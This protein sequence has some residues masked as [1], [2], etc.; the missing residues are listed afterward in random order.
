M[1]TRNLLPNNFLTSAGTTDWPQ[2]TEEYLVAAP[3]V[4]LFVRQARPAV[5]TRARVVLVHGLG[6]HLGR[7]GHVASA[8]LSRGF[9]VAGWDL[10]GHGRSSGVRG[11]VKDTEWLVDDLATVCAHFREEGCPLFIFAHSLGA[12]I[13]LRFLE[14]E[15]GVCRG[16]VIASPWLRLAFHPPRWKLLIAR[17][18]MWIRPGFVQKTKLRAERLSRDPAHLASFPHPELAHRRISA[19]MYFA[20]LAGGERI[21]AEAARLHT[22]MLLLHGDDDPVTSHR[23]TCDFFERV[24]SQDKTLRVFP[25]ARHEM[26]NDLD[27][28]EVL[29]E[30][31]GWIEARLAVSAVP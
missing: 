22:P 1:T 6:E 12:Q 26:H 19:R 28:A 24:G 16:A 9:A 8:L 13:A 30:I 18:A 10:R 20:L 27:R 5:P 4:Q 23:A 21:F 17:L 3:E 29:R 11:D 31:G 7:Y 25:G 2:S 15:G 14:R